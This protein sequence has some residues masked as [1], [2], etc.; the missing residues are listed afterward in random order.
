MSESLY[1]FLT[2]Q[3]L[4]SIIELL[5]MKQTAFTCQICEKPVDDTGFRLFI[6]HE[7]CW[8]IIAEARPFRKKKRID[9]MHGTNTTQ[10][11]LCKKCLKIKNKEIS[12]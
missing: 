6:T 12:I 3:L 2:N 7:I 9:H 8:A 4:T 11:R 5:I 1:V 10:I